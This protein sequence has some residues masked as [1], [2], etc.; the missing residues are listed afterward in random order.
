MPVPNPSEQW[1][2]DMPHPVHTRQF[3]IRYSNSIEN[4]RDKTGTDIID[5]SFDVEN[6]C[7]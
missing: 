2:K 4:K 1:L 6:V 5:S 3:N 7:S